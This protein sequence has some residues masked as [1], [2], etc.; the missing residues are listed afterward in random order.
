LNDITA[1]QLHVSPMG[2]AALL[3]EH[4]NEQREFLGKVVAE[5]EESGV[6]ARVRIGIG[7]PVEGILEAAETEEVDLIVIATHGRSGLRRLMLGS[8]AEGVLR[9]TQCPVLVCPIAKDE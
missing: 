4:Q 1:T 6:K 7:G 8:V 2:F 5:L 3:E 9:R